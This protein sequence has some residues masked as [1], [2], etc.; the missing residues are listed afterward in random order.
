MGYLISN[1]PFSMPMI[2]IISNIRAL[3][4]QVWSPLRLK[5]SYPAPSVSSPLPNPLP[6]HATSGYGGFQRSEF[7]GRASLSTGFPSRIKN[8]WQCGFKVTRTSDMVVQAAQEEFYLGV[9]FRQTDHDREARCPAVAIGLLLY[10]NGRTLI[11]TDQVTA[12]RLGILIGIGYK[13]RGH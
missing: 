5:M 6:I 4:A 13:R 7:G 12:T 8:P 3:Y 9:P 2:G 10:E 11:S 1:R